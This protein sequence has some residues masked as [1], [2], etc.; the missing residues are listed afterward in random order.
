MWPWIKVRSASAYCR[1]SKNICTTRPKET[2]FLVLEKTAQLKN[3]LHEVYTY[4]L[5]GI[6]SKKHETSRL[7]FKICELNVFLEP[8][9]H[10]LRFLL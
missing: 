6:F 3:A 5:E 9:V 2:Q 8:I 7:L 10:T 1:N 4:A